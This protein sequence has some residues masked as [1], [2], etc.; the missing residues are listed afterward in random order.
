MWKHEAWGLPNVA[1]TRIFSWSPQ[2]VISKNWGPPWA[3]LRGSR[4]DPSTPRPKP[5]LTWACR[6]AQYHLLPTL[7]TMPQA[8]VGSPTWSASLSRVA[9]FWRPKDKGESCQSP[10]ELSAQASSKIC[11]HLLGA[12]ATIT[13][14]D[15]IQRQC[16]LLS[17]LWPISTSQVGPSPNIEI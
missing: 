14:G 1:V 9:F 7:D 11:T 4:H 3:G 2:G 13:P 6:H 15:S 5:L 12:E 16:Q 8:A 17:C 10:V